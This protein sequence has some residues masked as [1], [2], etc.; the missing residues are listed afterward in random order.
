MV[1][2]KINVNFDL[3]KIWVDGK[4][5]DCIVYVNF[6]YNG[7]V[8]ICIFFLGFWEFVYEG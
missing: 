8:D 7:L 5:Y 2:V 3:G 6:K 1:G 4:I